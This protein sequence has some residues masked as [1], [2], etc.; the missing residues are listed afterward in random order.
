M[1]EAITENSVEVLTI[2][3]KRNPPVVFLA[4]PIKH[5]NP[6]FYHI[7]PT[8]PKTLATVQD[9][10]F[11][12][13]I[14][15]NFG[16]I[17]QILRF[18]K[19]SKL[20]NKNKVKLPTTTLET[21]E[22]YSNT[23]G[24]VFESFSKFSGW[25][26]FSLGDKSLS[27]NSTWPSSRLSTTT[28]VSVIYLNSSDIFTILLFFSRSIPTILSSLIQLTIL[29]TINSTQ[30]FQTNWVIPKR[31]GN[32]DS[33]RLLSITLSLPTLLTNSET[34]CYLLQNNTNPYFPHY[35]KKHQR[36]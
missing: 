29:R 16:K 10:E 22:I 18:S 15:K 20:T 7:A 35:L 27:P 34:S 12:G 36:S 32:L 11:F 3:T 8:L 2:L 19:P 4:A 17:D 28:S 26:T 31:F 30:V 21:F 14:P 1:I 5:L 6:D 13:V 25:P 33:N 24:I 9:I 23:I